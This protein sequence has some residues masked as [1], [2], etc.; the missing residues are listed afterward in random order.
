MNNFCTWHWP[1]DKALFMAGRDV[2][3]LTIVT[4]EERKTEILSFFF[5]DSSFFGD[6]LYNDTHNC[7]LLKS[8]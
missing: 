5:Y 3:M 1:E 8:I 4:P 7:F 2:K 6:F